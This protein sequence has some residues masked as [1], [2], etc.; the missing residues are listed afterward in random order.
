MPSRSAILQPHRLEKSMNILEGLQSGIL[1]G[2][3]G[4]IFELE[5]RGYVSAGPFT[6]EVVLEHPDAVRQMQVD[7]ARCGAD[8]LQAVT[9]YAHEE[10][11]RARG[12]EA[13]VEELN[14]AAV[15][16]ARQVGQEYGCYVA[17]N[18]SN[19]WVY[20]PDDPAAATETRRQFDQQIASQ[21]AVGVDFFIAETMEYL[22]EAKIA[23]ESIRAAGVPAMITMGFKDRDTTLEETPLEEAFAALE[24]AGADI[25]GLNCF[26]DPEHMMPLARRARQA[27]GCFLATQPVAYNC[28]C[29]APHYFQ[30]QKID[31]RVAFPLDLDPITLPRS[32]MAAYAL[33]AREAGVNF[34]GSC[35]GAGPHH[36]RAIAEALGRVTPNSRW[37]PQLTLHPIIGDEDHL[38]ERNADTLRNQRGL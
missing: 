28:A 23:L 8:V 36:V 6:P 21:M 32:A 19:T 25:V 24:G 17:G 15:R 37:T 35:C 31:G 10:K 14:A 5:R 30:A 2:D 7:F 38:R 12:L 34:V 9:Y 1:V 22:G 18:L 26:Q 13:S 16:I 11:L 27:V 29:N 3:G 4:A 33:D 20:A